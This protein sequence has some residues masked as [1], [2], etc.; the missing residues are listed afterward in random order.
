MSVIVYATDG[1]GAAGVAGRLIGNVTWPAGTSVRVVTVVPPAHE[2]VMSPWV[3]VGQVDVQ[4]V[5]AAELER[6]QDNAMSWAQELGTRGVTADWVVLRGRPAEA[7]T[8][9]AQREGADLIVVGS[10]G[11][12]AVEGALLGSVS[13]GVV[14]RATCPVLVARLPVVTRTVVADDGSPGA[15]LAVEYVRTRPH[16][17]GSAVRVLSVFTVPELWSEAFDLPLDARS[18]QLFAEDRIA[19]REEAR[20]RLEESAASLPCPSGRAEPELDE[21]RPGPTIVD[22]AAK[23]PADLVVVGSRHRTGLSR[24]VLGSVGRHVLNHAHCSVLHVGRL[25]TPTRPAQTDGEESESRLAVA[26]IAR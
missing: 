3:P 13:D 4:Q 22:A 5:E 2:L 10:R 17:L 1:S 16:L 25:A 23:W 21:G 14:D 6:A 26:A 24:L 9:L 15:A 19:L 7:I 20:R 12:G 11:L 18:A 8:D